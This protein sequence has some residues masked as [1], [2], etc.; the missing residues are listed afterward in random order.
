MARENHFLKIALGVAIFLFLGVAV[1]LYFVST[2]YQKEFERANTADQTAKD[3]NNKLAE[4]TR[5]SLDLR[6][7]I[8]VGDTD[9]VEDIAAM[10]QQ[11]IDRVLRGQNS[12]V[13]PTY[14]RIVDFLVGNLNVQNDKL[15]ALNSKYAT[16]TADFNNL[17]ALREQINAAH[18]TERVKAGADLNS[19]RNAYNTSKAELDKN[20]AK[21]TTDLE[22]SKTAFETQAKSAEA[23]KNLAMA[24]RD[25]AVNVSKTLTSELAGLKSPVVERPDGEI[26]AVSQGRGVVSLNLGRDDGL[27]VRMV[28]TVYDPSVLSI[29]LPRDRTDHADD[30]V[31]SVCKRQEKLDIAKASI[32]VTRITGPHSAEARILNDSI[33]NPIMTGDVVYTPIWK[34]GQKLRFALEDGLAIKA[35]SA[36]E[37]MDERESLE[38]VRDLIRSNGGEVD[39][40]IDA[41]GKQHGEVTAA[42]TYRVVGDPADRRNHTPEAATTREKMKDQAETYAIKTVAL[43]SL[44]H[45]MGYK[46]VT[47]V[48]GFGD[49][50]REGDHNV[51]P[52]GGGRS[53]ANGSVALTYRP[54]NIEARVDNDDRAKPVSD[55]GK[56]S[57]FI[58]NGTQPKTATAGSVSELFRPRKPPIE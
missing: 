42:T 49:L 24:A 20:V 57:S 58:D 11:D 26:I 19:E 54:D 45:M 38:I 51:S 16:L 8:G 40:Y 1:A 35:S 17:N 23:E 48:R 10:F 41:D 33:G 6:A 22:T 50:S 15:D 27:L 36:S 9:T 5:E 43:T 28:F 13:A 21:L 12:S 4:K 29:T 18:D 47:P 56:V 32:E 44:L 2:A 31:C 46:D 52:T 34:P 7:K 55:T 37:S 3:A 53:G 25:S 14:R 30:Y 39:A